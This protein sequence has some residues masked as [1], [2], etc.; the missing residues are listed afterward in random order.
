MNSIIVALPA[1]NEEIG[2][3]KLLDKLINVRRYMTKPLEVVIVNDGSTDRTKQ[4]LDHYST[5]YPFITYIDHE[6]NKGLGEAMKTLFTH[7]LHGYGDDDI[8]VTL[9]ADNT[10]NP[11]I[12]PSIV[13]KLEKEK[14]DVVIASR[15]TEGGIEVGLSPLR[16]LYSRGAKLFFKVFFPIANVNDY[17]SGYRAYR[18]QYLRKAFNLYNGKVITS[19][20][21]ECMVELLARFSKIGIKVGE[22][23][24]VLEYHLKETPS[25]MNVVKTITGYF[26]LL[27]KVKKPPRLN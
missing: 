3:P 16:K 14:L 24:L 26:T 20:G 18:I 19:N 12:I 23:P 25:K 5:N 13:S 2:L 1:Y 8:V 15:F 21:F 11:N 7:I 27:S 10:H 9:D 6:Q 22:Y 4:V 17:S